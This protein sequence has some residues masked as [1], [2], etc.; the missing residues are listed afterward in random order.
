MPRSLPWPNEKQYTPEIRYTYSMVGQSFEG[1]GNQQ[2]LFKIYLKF[3]LPKL[4]KI[5][6][7][8]RLNSKNLLPNFNIYSE[9]GSQFPP[10]MQPW[11]TPL[12]Q[13][14]IFF[15]QKKIPLGVLALDK[16]LAT[17][18]S[19]RLPNCLVY[20]PFHFL[21]IFGRIL[22]LTHFDVISLLRRCHPYFLWAPTFKKLSLF[23]TLRSSEEEAEKVFFKQEKKGFFHFDW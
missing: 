14:F 13:N 21:R 5:Y 20:S 17:G 3:F 9:P 10:F 15:F 8:I 6:P 23:R 16:C 22:K 4:Q 2:K 18:I 19:A 11:H 1:T 12:D 7:H